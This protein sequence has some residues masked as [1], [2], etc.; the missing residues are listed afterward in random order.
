MVAFARANLII[1][2]GQQPNAHFILMDQN[3]LSPYVR[4][5]AFPLF[6]HNTGEPREEFA[7]LV[8]KVLTA[9]IDPDVSFINAVFKET[10]GHPFLT[11]NLLADFVDWL[12]E[13]RRP[14]SGLAL[15]S[16]DVEQFILTRLGRRHVGMCRDYTFFREAAGQA[17]SE[18][19][20]IGTPWLH[21][22][23]SSMSQ[24]VRSA[25]ETLRCTRGDFSQIASRIQGTV[26]P[27]RLLL[28]ASDSNFLAYDDQH[29]WP[30]I[31]LLGRIAGVSQ[32]VVQG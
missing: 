7:Q 4:Q 24:L 18:S 26:D 6:G 32:G 9:P 23:Y 14:V 21:A 30:K 22:V 31:R 5:D 10:A 19:G 2:L 13:Q 16:D 20:K 29:V 27:D 11:V 12:I 3:Q 17:M 8:R 1:F 25:P 15:T 28:T